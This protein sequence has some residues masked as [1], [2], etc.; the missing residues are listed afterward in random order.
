MKDIYELLND[1][2]IDFSDVKEME[3]ND[4]ERKRGR[5][6]LI[7][8]IKNNNKR[9]KK[10]VAAS[11]ASLIIIGGTVISESMINPTW[12]QNIPIIGNLFEKTY[13]NDNPEF[14]DYVYVIGQT[15]SYDGLDI[16]FEN[17]AADN[18]VLIIRYIVKDNKNPISSYFDVLSPMMME[19]NGES[20]GISGGADGE[21]IDSNT[22]RIIQTIDWNIEDFSEKINVEMYDMNKNIDIK[23]SMNTKE[24]KNNTKQYEVDKD[25]EVDRRNGKFENITVSPVMTQIKYYIEEDENDP[26]YGFL[27]FDQDGNEMK[28]ETGRSTTKGC[29]DYIE[30]RIDYSDKYVTRKDVSSLTFI[31]RK[32]SSKKSSKI[33]KDKINLDNFQQK[34]IK[35]SDTISLVIEDI[36]TYEDKLLIKYCFYY[37]GKKAFGLNGAE[38][39]VNGLSESELSMEEYE[40]YRQE[41]EKY[42][43]YSLF[44]YDNSKEIEIEYYDD[45]TENLFEDKAFTIDL[46]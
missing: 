26:W 37:K 10:W 22:V 46:K 17:A 1:V 28:F 2:N 38:F 4:L 3:V 39:T 40:K 31:P 42:S 35:V 41:D 8:S 13:I 18:N 45:K 14:E 36:K 16:T 24:I 20:V 19:V 23:F 27:V 11:V 6:K 29:E 21:R 9:K 34:S 43:Y 15:S 33:I 5:E 25:F 7:N 32:Y 44:E 30:G 12:A